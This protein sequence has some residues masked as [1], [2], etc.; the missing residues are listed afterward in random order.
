[1]K[2]R[3]A[4][5]SSTSLP[6]VEQGVVGFDRCGRAA[7]P[8]H[9]SP[10]KGQ[11]RKPGFGAF[12]T[13]TPSPVNSEVSAPTAGMPHALFAAAASAAPVRRTGNEPHP[14]DRRDGL[15]V[16]IVA[17]FRRAPWREFVD[18]DRHRRRGGSGRR[19]GL[20][21]APPRASRSRAPSHSFRD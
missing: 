7:E 1:M 15:D 3:G 13:I 11:T 4:A 19:S 9:Q 20:S 16:A 18:L 14:D 8:R 10:A 17:Q 21:P 12:A 6:L 5:V 2:D